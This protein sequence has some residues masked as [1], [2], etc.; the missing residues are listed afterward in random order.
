MGGATMTQLFAN[1]EDLAQHLCASA[2]GSL[3]VSGS[4]ISAQRG[5]NG[6]GF[7]DVAT[8]SQINTVLPDPGFEPTSCVVVS[9]R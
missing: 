3:L 7:V 9:A 8:S 2:D 1:T 4:A 5:A 6:V